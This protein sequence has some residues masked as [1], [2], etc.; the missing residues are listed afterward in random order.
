MSGPLRVTVE[1]IEGAGKTHLSRLAAERLGDRCRLLGE[2]TDQQDSALAVRVMTALS[3]GG[4][5]WLRTGHP[6]TETLALL[7]LKAAA[8]EHAAG[9]GHA[10]LVLEDRGIDTVAVYQALILAG[11]AA[12]DSEVRGLMDQVYGTARRWLPLPGLTLLIT[13]DP[14]AC[15]SRLQQRTGRQ[16]T[17]GD[18]ALMIR[19]A[20]LYGQ[21]AAREPGRFRVISRAG[22]TADETV[23]DIIAACTAAAGSG[24]EQMARA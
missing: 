15:V 2:I 22:R 24:K 19:A 12:P 11:P 20:R 3:R 5:L 17:P 10:G 4:D 18:R 13:D 9:G 8:H 6:V 1:G 14:D 7:A 16:V 23:A 21:Q